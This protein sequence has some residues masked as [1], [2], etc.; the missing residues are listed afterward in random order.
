[1]PISNMGEI[2]AQRV[3]D[4]LYIILDTIFLEM[5]LTVLIVRKRYAT[6]LFSLFGGVL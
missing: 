6:V 1:M 2:G 3:F 5:L 4:P